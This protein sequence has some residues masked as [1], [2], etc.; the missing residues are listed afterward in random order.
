M[1]SW[2]NAR[3]AIIAGAFGAMICG[4][5]IAQVFTLPNNTQLLGHLISGAATPP[6]G[7]GCTI[8]AGSS[9]TDGECTTSATSGT[10]VF[11]AA[12]VSAPSCTVTD[13]SATSTVSMPVYTTTTTQITLTTIISAHGLVWH[14]AAK[15]GG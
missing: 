5:V 4:S 9:D 13:K 6:V 12:Y 7:T 10:I 15:I 3:A 1:R 2:M 14:C 8:I 11:G